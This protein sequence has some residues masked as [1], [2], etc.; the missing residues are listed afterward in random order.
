MQE[1]PGQGVGFQGSPDAQYCSY[2]MP[3]LYT[4]PLLGGIQY[5]QEMIYCGNDWAGHQQCHIR[6]CRRH[7]S[8][9]TT[10]CAQCR[11]AVRRSNQRNGIVPQLVRLGAWES[12]QARPCWTARSTPATGVMRNAIACAGCRHTALRNETRNPSTTFYGHHGRSKCSSQAHLV[13][14]HDRRQG[15]GKERNGK[16]QNAS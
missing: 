10:W 9:N 8:D 1:R 16:E 4:Q 12:R 5:Y 11:Q 2:G 3:P 6:V 7:V 13:E 15:N 14:G